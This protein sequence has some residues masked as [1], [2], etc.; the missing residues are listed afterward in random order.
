MKCQ[1]NGKL[2]SAANERNEQKM[3]EP[4]TSPSLAAEGAQV[5]QG[6]GPACVPGAVGSSPSS[7][8][9]QSPTAPPSSREPNA[10]QRQAIEAPV[11]A[12]VRVLAPPGAGKTFLIARRYAHLLESGAEPKDILAVTFSK[13]MSKELLVRIVKVSPDVED[14]EAQDQVCTIHAACYRML[15]KDGD[16]RRVPKTWQ[17]KKA[18]QD[19]AENLWPYSEERPGWEELMAWV[20]IP[21]HKGLTSAE[22]LGFYIEC[23]GDYNGRN[24]HETR[25]RFD[26]KM[27]Q[28]NFI[29]FADMLFD[30]EQ[31]LKQDKAFRERW[32]SRYQW[33]IVD[34]GQD[35]S[36]Q[37][38]RILTTLAEPQ[39]QFFIAG[40][41]DQLL[42]RFAGAT[43]E[44][45]LYEGFEE[46]Y[47]EGFTVK[48]AI[49]YRS[50]H[51]IVNACQALIAHNYEC[52]GGQYDDKYRKETRPRDGAQ[53][54][55]ALTFTAYDNPEEEARAL[56][57]GLQE[58]LANGRQPGDMFVGARTRAQLGYLEGPLTRAKIPFINATGGS[59]WASKHVADV[60]AYLALAYD[61]SNDVAFQRV[62][63]IATNWNIHPWG[64]SKGEYCHHRYL[65]RAFIDACGGKY[66]N[67]WQAVSR[68]RSFAPG[69]DDLTRFVDEL[70]TELSCSGPAEVLQM[71][72]DDCYAKYLKADQGITSNDE[73]ENGK[74]EDLATAI[75]VASQFS[76][77][78]EF[79]DYVREAVKASI[80]AK[81]KDWSEFV[82]ISTVHRLK[83]LEREVVYGV[84]MSE[85]EKAALLPHTFSIL[86]PP[87]NGVLPTGGMS[88]MSDERCIAFVLVSR[89]KSEVHLSGIREYRRNVMH[90]SRFV[91]ELG[92]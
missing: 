12:A 47:P 53:V 66:A 7:N 55:N 89:A 17:M 88:R 48:L 16:H 84:G 20:N 67:V 41:A 85:G 52:G 1:E 18:L 23:L 33:V 10:E 69:V 3:T 38:M 6:A 5:P 36:G 65:G 86:P 83:G 61:A 87:Q 51:A 30:T 34:E 35:T 68:R 28:Q 46:R 11:N 92:L 39:N 9:L 26:E 56:V 82:V 15:H 64:E 29:T 81:N 37:A 74:L 71:I 19:I 75:D 2:A 90:S 50:T 25:K 62:Y 58:A 8:H 57:D 54:G 21:K 77:V 63:N 43:P 24:L 70:K 42:Y 60:V 32:Q 4:N 59:F 49:N 40:D 13:D 91:G 79:I 78:G 80:A 45:N 73:A 22:D 76:D 72:V 44:A 31:K 27:R 14:T